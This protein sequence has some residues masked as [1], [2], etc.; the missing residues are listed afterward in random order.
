MARL[1]ASWLAHTGLWR[2]LVC[3]FL[4]LPLA[5]APYPLPARPVRDYPAPIETLCLRGGE[6]D[7]C[8]RNGAAWRVVAGPQRPPTR[9]GGRRPPPTRALRRRIFFKPAPCAPTLRLMRRCASVGVQTT[10][11]YAMARL[12]ASWRAHNGLRHVA[13]GCALSPCGAVS[14]TRPP[15]CAHG[16]R[17]MR[18]CA[19]VGV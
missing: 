17:P 18:R 8:L 4:P 13:V 9:G 15:P 1:G 5:A 10:A 6:R 19:S 11:A 2:V 14:T 16:L 3:G 7:C 12:A